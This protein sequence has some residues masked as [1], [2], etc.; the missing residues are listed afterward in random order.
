MERVSKQDLTKIVIHG[1]ATDIFIAERAFSLFKEIGDH[2]DLVRRPSGLFFKSAQ[3]AFKDQ[4]LLALARLFDNASKKN[5]TRCMEGLLKFIEK[6][7]SRMPL[8]VERPNLVK[9]LR[10]AGFT[11]KTVALAQDE[12]CDAQL[13]TSIVQHF[14]R[15]LSSQGN[16]KLLGTLKT[17]RDKRLAHNELR[18]EK[19]LI[20]TIDVVTFQD[21]YALL[22]IAKDFL[23]IIGWAYMS[24]IFMHNGEYHLSKDAIR[25]IHSLK[26]LLESLK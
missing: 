4:Y 16:Q 26:K 3:E 21:L 5:P 11:E 14:E 9:V 25:P 22:S 1:L 7:H 10:S 24:T 2:P 12:S 19:Q 13:A 18:P 15:V 8:I 17:I 6:N 23:G 20:D